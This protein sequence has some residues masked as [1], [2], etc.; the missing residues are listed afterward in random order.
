[1]A[2]KTYEA[3]PYVLFEKGGIWF[4][5]DHERSDRERYKFAEAF[6]MHGPIYEKYVDYQKLIGSEEYKR[7]HWYVGNLYET[8]MHHI[9]SV[10]ATSLEGSLGYLTSDQFSSLDG[11]GEGIRF[12]GGAIY[13]SPEAGAHVISDPVYDKWAELDYE[14]GVS[15]IL[16]PI[17]HFLMAISCHKYF[18]MVSYNQVR[19]NKKVTII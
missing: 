3:V 6:E 14:N 10:T 7:T 11:V 16:L 19:G 15:V 12:S 17:L 13:W 18:R 5:P 1:M 9:A 4:I 8:E 2:S